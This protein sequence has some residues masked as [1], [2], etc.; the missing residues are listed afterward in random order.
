LYYYES[1]WERLEKLLAILTQFDTSD[2]DTCW[3]ILSDTNGGE[4]NNNTICRKG[5]RTV[6]TVTNIFT[7]NKF[8]YTLGR[9]CEYLDIY[10]G[11]NVIDFSQLVNACPV[12][13][14]YGE[15]AKETKLLRYFR[16]TVLRKT[17]EG[18]ELIRLYYEWSDTIVKLLEGDEKF[19][20]EVK[21][22]IDGMLPLI[23]T[24]TK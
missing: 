8:Y 9:P 21:T 10:D 6:T 22:L 3:E 11:P 19:K 5:Y 12:E 20:G 18:K 4:P 16:D 2:L 14:L 13:T 24:V 1:S 7:K 15:N 23:S 17:S